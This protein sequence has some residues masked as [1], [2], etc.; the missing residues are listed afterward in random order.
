[1]L[2]ILIP[3]FNGTVEPLVMRL[4]EQAALLS[5]P[6]E[7]VVCEDASTDTEAREAN[8]NLSN[9][10]RLIYLE[11]DTNM[12]RI[13]TRN[14]LAATAQ[15]PW[16]LFLD[17]DVMPPDD[18]FLMRY[19][20]YFEKEFELIM[21]GFAYQ[22]VLPKVSQSL[23]WKFGRNR[24]S[25]NAVLRNKK[26][27][28]V[29]ISANYLIKKTVYLD[30]IGSLNIPTYGSDSAIAAVLL[31]H[32]TKVLHID[33]PVWHMGLEE[34][35]VF[36]EKTRSAV[37]T[38]HTLANNNPGLLTQNKLYNAF[39]KVKFLHCRQPIAF[40]FKLFRVPMEKQLTGKNPALFL[41]D[42]YRLGY[43]CHLYN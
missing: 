28:R 26:P 32:K 9:R 36:L 2:S 18:S 6:W 42:L 5:V 8:R 12:G 39:L 41:F 3:V 31:S 21:G 14:R 20:S 37:C 10:H 40:F 7:I 19:V 34:N 13:A 11:N 24:E 23:R 27:Y 33:N 29:F 22:A 25:I 15:Y 4:R 30:V 16:L 35:T 38:L 17:A 43:L 1:M